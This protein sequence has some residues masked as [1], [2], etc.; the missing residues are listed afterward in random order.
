MSLSLADVIQYERIFVEGL[1][2]GDVSVADAAFAPE[3]VI[4]FTGVP[5]PVRGVG[6]WKQ[7]VA[8]FLA[9]FPDLHFTIEEQIIS[10]DRVVIRWRATG[11]HKGPLGEVPPTGK[12][13]SIDGLILD[14]IAQGRVVERWEQF[15]Q[16][17]M[18]QQLGLV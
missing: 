14:R 12:S 9:A 8:G 17:R 3:C 7:L 11:T 16:P 10:G 13:I 1:H 4:H 6:A 15:D 2:R 5:D 18:L